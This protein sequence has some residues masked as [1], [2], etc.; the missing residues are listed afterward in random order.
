MSEMTPEP[1]IP[2]HTVLVRFAELAVRIY[3]EIR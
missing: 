2:W 3:D 1:D